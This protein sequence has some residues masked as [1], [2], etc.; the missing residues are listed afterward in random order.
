MP[1]AHGADEERPLAVLVHHSLPRDDMGAI[2][3][4]SSEQPGDLPS[5][6]A[7]PEQRQPGTVCVC[8]SVCVLEMFMSLRY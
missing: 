6:L 3:T 4:F 8:V 5:T 7:D 1:R 2:L